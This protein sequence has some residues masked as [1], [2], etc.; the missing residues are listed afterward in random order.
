MENGSNSALRI[1]AVG[2]LSYFKGIDVLLRATAQIPAARLLIIGDGECRTALER[3][4]RELDIEA[5]VRFSGRIDM[6][7]AGAEA[8]QAAYADADIFCLP[9]TDRAESFGL[10]LLEAMRAR[11]PVIASAIPGSGINHVVRAGETGLL[12]PPGDVAALAGALRRLGADA[13][14][15]ARLGAAGER[16]WR[17]EFTLDRA[18]ERTLEL[19]RRVGQAT[20]DRASAAP[21]G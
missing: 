17:D 15:R 13:A 8:L 1:L 4:A 6:D 21:S 16:R 9:S 5:R 14:L 18:A 11:L 19:Y 10:V 2:R 7:A 3:L 20:A 12:V